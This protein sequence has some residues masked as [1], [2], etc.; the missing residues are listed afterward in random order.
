[1]PESP[2]TQ[3][4]RN[5]A[6][7]KPV[8]ETPYT[9]AAAEAAD[10]LQGS[11]PGEAATSGTALADDV[12]LSTITTDDDLDS[13]SAYRA[14][15]QRRR[16]KR[17]RRIGIGIAAAALL[18]AG[19][20]GITLFGMQN[21]QGQE[22][23][24]LPT[25]IVT[26]TDYEASV[27]AT[28]STQPNTQVVVTPEVEGIIE[29]V[30]VAEGDTVSKGDT[31]LTIKNDS[32][33]R[34][35]LDAEQAVRQAE[36]G[37]SAAERSVQSANNAYSTAASNY[38]SVFS[39]GYETQEEAD[40]A[41]EAAT[42]ALDTA[43]QGVDSA[44]LELD[45]ARIALDKAREGLSDAQESADKRTITA[46]ASGAVVSLN[47]KVGAGIGRA[48]GSTTG[49][50][51]TGSLM[52]IADLSQ[53]R[54][55]VQVNEVDIN[56]VQVGQKAEVTF[57]SI[58]DMTLEAEVQHIAALASGSGEANAAAVG[59]VVTYDVEL[60]IPDPDPR[61]K[62]G[63]T[64]RVKIVSE[65]LEHVLTV[66]TGALED[67]GDG[68]A[69]VTVVVDGDASKAQEKQV[70]ILAKDSTT[71]AIEGDLADGD[72]VLLAIDEDAAATDGAAVA[73]D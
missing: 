34:A 19:I 52:T 37:V 31:L 49:E 45:N 46:P 70:S 57:S 8:V 68:T 73:I 20:A 67:N 72:E 25:G 38:D 41:G 44:N 2:N 64:A 71:A 58:E 42:T 40:A 21:Q 10:A 7:V 39:K 11:Q 22:Q 51:V 43:Q 9:Q 62:P 13:I 32:L 1:M 50:S 12:D 61:V 26:V 69:T 35:V 66:P 4:A 47:A 54:V 15:E 55:T 28:G 53:M 23:E 29:S 33:G 48:T 65:R 17:H 59:G 5:Q 30:M 6:P 3:D 36:N 24:E 60:L 16:K 56:K 27:S 14:I 63:M 18:L